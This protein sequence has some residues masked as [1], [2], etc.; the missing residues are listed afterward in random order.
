MRDSGGGVFASSPFY[1]KKWVLT[2]YGEYV[3]LL[4]KVGIR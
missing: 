3:I 1:W 4:L 2:G